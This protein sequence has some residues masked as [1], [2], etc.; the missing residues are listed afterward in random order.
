MSGTDTAIAE[1]N[2]P[3]AEPAAAA[4]GPARGDPVPDRGR[5]HARRSPGTSRPSARPW[6]ANR[7]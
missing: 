3:T 2:E 5:T 1:L 7:S 6:S 4:H